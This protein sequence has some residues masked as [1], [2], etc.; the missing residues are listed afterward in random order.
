MNL[1]GIAL[2]AILQIGDPPADPIPL[3]GAPESWIFSAPG[4]EGTEFLVQIPSQP[5][6]V[7]KLSP[8]NAWEFN[9]IFP[10]LGRAPAQPEAYTLRFRTYVQTRNEERDLGPPVS[11]MLLQLWGYNIRRLRLEHSNA[12]FLQLVDVY[13]CDLGK[14]GGEQL[15]GEDP[16]N[17][18]EF[19][20]PRRANQIYIYDL[21]S[22]SDPV[23]MAREIAHEYGHATLPP[24][25]GFES[26]ES[27]ANGYLGET[28]YLTWMARDA[29]AGKLQLVDSMGADAEMLTEY[30]Q[31]KIAPLSKEVGTNGPDLT[32]FKSKDQVSM[33]HFLGL[34]LHAE[35][36]L[37]EGAFR[38]SLMLTGIVGSEYPK[39]IVEAASEVEELTLNVPEYFRGKPM[40]IPLGKGKLNGLKPLKSRAGWVQVQPKAAIIRV[41]NPKT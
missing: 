32:K 35:S 30:H 27:W 19:G 31:T 3:T 34:A 2:L 36:I 1:A 13:L 33:N 22:F 7:P 39:S 5:M 29:K 37:P 10:G 4:S 15:F 23:E 17:V 6:K 26:P 25:G 24:I 28:L 21:A 9:W 41:K 38:R 18:D 16:F 14:P 40:W 11:R 12:Y 8:K 20:R